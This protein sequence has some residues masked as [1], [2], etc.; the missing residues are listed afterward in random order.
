[1]VISKT[2]KMFHYIILVANDET[3]TIYQKEFTVPKT[4]RVPK[5]VAQEQLAESEA[6]IRIISQKEVS[7]TYE[8]PVEV[9]IKTATKKSIKEKEKE[10]CTNQ[11]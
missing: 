5:L 4:R 1:M 11:K 8:M 7:V 2:L 9:F 6:L 3:E 10:T